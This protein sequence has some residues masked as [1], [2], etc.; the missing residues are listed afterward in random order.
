MLPQPNFGRDKGPIEP[1][2]DE[3]GEDEVPRKKLR[4]LQIAM[5][6][7]VVFAVLLGNLHAFRVIG[8]RDISEAEILADY[9]EQP[10]PGGISPEDA[11]R[12]AYETFQSTEFM[13]FMLAI[14]GFAIVAAIVAALCAI[15][16]KSR[17]K[18]VRWWAVGATAILFL[19]GMYMS[20]QFGLLVAPWVF[21]SVLA[22][23]W[24]F[25]SDIRYWLNESAKS[26]AE[27]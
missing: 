4:R 20:T 1:A 21:A 5:W 13:V 16:L 7:Q 27:G 8:A 6:V 10:P 19:V 11:A 26:R 15:R 9:K 2:K 14:S 22:L 3:H 12:T 25:A 23:W 18:A 17:L 24:L